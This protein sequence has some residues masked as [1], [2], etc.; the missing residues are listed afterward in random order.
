MR[1]AWRA[2]LCALAL[3]AAACGGA[4][5]S[6][7]HADRR[8]SRIVELDPPGGRSSGGSGGS[9]AKGSSMRT[10]S[11]VGYVL[12]APKPAPAASAAKLPCMIA[13][14]GADGSRA[15]AAALLSLADETGIGGYVIAVLDG[16]KYNHI[17]VT[18]YTGGHDGA[19]AL[20][21]LRAKYDCDNDRT[22]LFSES[23]GSAAAFHLGFEIRQSYFAAFWA[24]DVALGDLEPAPD[25]RADAL[26]FAPWGN[27]G[28][29]G[30]LAK[31]Q[32]IVAS[33]AAAGYRVPP[34]APYDGPGANAHGD[35][36]QL[37]AGLRWIGGGTKTRQ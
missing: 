23:A 37:A 17:G 6:S 14:S 36:A 30:A 35:P 16:R 8:E 11:G 9:P 32:S 34:P 5:S 28:P 7:G 3:A 19:A 21:D 22:Y 20:D 26:H 1:R 29:G 18:D 27:V 13:Y 4:A 31:A 10:A 25:Q 2:G 12:I 15:M 33:M 24:N